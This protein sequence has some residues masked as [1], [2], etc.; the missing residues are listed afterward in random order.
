MGKETSKASG[1]ELERLKEYGGRKV[2]FQ[3]RTTRVKLRGENF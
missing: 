1:K 3:Q 2:R